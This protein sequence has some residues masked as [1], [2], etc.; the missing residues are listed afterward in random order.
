[1]TVSGLRYWELARG[2]HARGLRNEVRAAFSTYRQSVD[3]I[4]RSGALFMKGQI[5][6]L[7]EWEHPNG[8]MYVVSWLFAA[9]CGIGFFVFIAIAISEHFSKD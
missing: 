1:M 9:A 2:G 5:N 7:G 3:L 6:Q 4:R 8:V